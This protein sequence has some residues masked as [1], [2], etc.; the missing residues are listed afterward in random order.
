MGES[1]LGG[2]L[3]FEFG[4][5]PEVEG[6]CGDDHG[7]VLLEAAKDA[8]YEF[9]RDREWELGSWVVW[10]PAQRVKHRGA[11]LELGAEFARVFVIATV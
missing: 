10:A 7:R 11:V 8:A 3:G 6:V 5:V 2:G 4:F 1:R 9:C